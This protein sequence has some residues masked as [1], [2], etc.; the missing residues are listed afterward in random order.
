MAMLGYGTLLC[1]FFNL[2]MSSLEYPSATPAFNLLDLMDNLPEGI[3]R[4][5]KIVKILSLWSLLLGSAGCLGCYLNKKRMNR[6]RLIFATLALAGALGTGITRETLPLLILSGLCFA[7]CLYGWRSYRPPVRNETNLFQGAFPVMMHHPS[8]L[9][10]ATGL[11]LLIL[12]QSIAVIFSGEGSIDLYVAFPFLLLG[13]AMFL[14][15]LW[16][17][18]RQF[19]AYRLP[20]AVA[21]LSSLAAVL[22]IV[23][24]RYLGLA[25]VTWLPRESLYL[26]YLIGDL[27]AL[28]LMWRITRRK[29]GR[30]AI[31]LIAQ[32]LLIAYGLSLI[33]V[34]ATLAL[35]LP[36]LV[37]AN[38]IVILGWILF[39]TDLYRT[40]RT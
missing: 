1:L 34:R 12:T 32:Y 10:L 22:D 29:A 21:A 36:I 20:L 13:R 28:A 3:E 15:A 18:S 35:Q 6:W 7:L 5:Q 30:I 2:P 40:R 26:V 14:C 9:I 24:T 31:L 11:L 16:K 17:T 38:L 19:R 8:C 4:T 33:S 39:M 23:C 27:T 37:Y 25:L